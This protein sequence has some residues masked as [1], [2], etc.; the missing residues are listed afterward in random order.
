MVTPFFFRQSVYAVNAA[1][2]PPPLVALPPVVV[3]P[4]LD[5]PPQAAASITAADATTVAATRTDAFDLITGTLPSLFDG[6]RPPRR[7]RTFASIQGSPVTYTLCGTKLKVRFEPI[8]LR[9]NSEPGPSR[10]Q[11]HAWTLADHG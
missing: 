2:P 8:P 7:T 10:R 6:R 9:G 4:E 5:P 3:E 11:G 1:F